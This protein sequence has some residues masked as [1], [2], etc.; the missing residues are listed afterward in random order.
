MKGNGVSV[1]ADQAPLPVE[2]PP[3]VSPARWLL[4]A[5]APG[6]FQVVFTLVL[7][8]VSSIFLFGRLG[9]YA[10]WDDE[11]ITALT[12]RGVWATGDTS[13][14]VGHNILAYRNGLLL[15]DMKDR[16]TPPLQFYLAAP[17]VGLLGDTA[18]AARL[19]F[20]MC[21]LACIA[22]M[23]W[24]MH[25]A[26]ASLLAW[27][28]LGLAIAGN[29][30]LFLFARQA[31]YY[32]LG[33]LLSVAVAYSYL[34]LR[35]R[36]GLL[37]HALLS[38][39]LLAANYM[40]FAAVTGM[41]LVDYAVWGHRR[42]PLRGWDWAVLLGPQAV[43]GAI[44]IWIWNP[45]RI[46]EDQPGVNW[47]TWHMT[48]FGWNLRDLNA[49][50]FGVGALLLAA[51]LVWLFTRPSWLLRATVA[52]VT[53]IVIISIVSPQN[54]SNT[55][56]ADV[57]Y[58]SFLIP[59]CIATGVITLVSAA[60]WAT[61][62][63]DRGREGLEWTASGQPIT[64]SSPARGPHFRFALIVAVASVAFLSNLLNFSFMT[65]QPLRS[66]VYQYARELIQPV[67]EPFTPVSRWIN[68]NTRVGDSVLVVPPYAMYPLMF[69]AP[70]ALYAW[71]LS[72]PPPL[73][74][75]HLS[76][77]HVAGGVPPQY[78]ILFGPGRRMLANMQMRTNEPLDYEQVAQIDVPWK[79]MYRPELFWRR[80]VPVEGFDPSTGGIVIYRRAVSP[81]PFRL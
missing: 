64:H 18:L 5:P 65:E 69:H 46:A 16:V 51:P 63:A 10:L 2:R 4:L 78:S 20:A 45:L 58:L 49:C 81:S 53:G 66:T 13:A 41:M 8:G 12:A 80:F 27:A 47:L 56:V 22:L 15:R 25:R 52:L 59:L 29:V 76:S 74:L 34:H 54:P 31:R 33:M 61:G 23:L 17:F 11:A 70:G 7:L 71:Q 43:L 57:R 35:T 55:G 32:G 38:I 79:D 28:L 62:S 36:R 72:D 60:H 44:I 77:V 6:R 68:D 9:Q 73:G 67:P 19:P 14:I 30:S 40:T 3:A 37:F 50:E 48:L 21:G 24:W 26:G 75:S 39:L 42:R 1:T